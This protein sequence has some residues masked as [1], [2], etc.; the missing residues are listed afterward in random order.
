MMSRTSLERNGGCEQK[1]HEEE[2]DVPFR[3]LSN[4]M[5]ISLNYVLL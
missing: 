1:P 5:E 4:G 2:Q 3:L